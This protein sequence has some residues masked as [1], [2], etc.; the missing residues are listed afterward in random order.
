MSLPKPECELGYPVTQL[1]SVLGDRFKEFGQWMYG[2]TMALCDGRSYNHEKR[3]YEET[4]CGP[5]GTICYAWDV[6]R[7][8]AGRPIVD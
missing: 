3:E 1:A 4:G 8:L 5:H 2:Q 6:E 7:F